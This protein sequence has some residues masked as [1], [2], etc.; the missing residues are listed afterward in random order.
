[1]SSGGAEDFGK[2]GGKNKKSM[3]VNMDGVTSATNGGGGG[4]T[5]RGG[6]GASSKRS[7]RHRGHIDGETRF[8]GREMRLTACVAI[9][10][11]VLF[12]LAA[13]MLVSGPLTG[14]LK[15]KCLDERLGF[16]GLCDSVDCIDISYRS[17]HSGNFS[18][19]PC[20]D[21][22]H[23]ACSKWQAQNPI[24]DEQLYLAAN[25]NQLRD[26]VD[27]FLKTLLEQETPSHKADPGVTALKNFYKS[28]TNFTN[29]NETELITDLL[30]SVQGYKTTE[31]WSEK[32]FDLTEVILKFLKVNA[33]PLIDLTLDI[34]AKNRER[35]ALIIE[36]PRATSL[37]PNLFRPPR[38]D[39]DLMNSEYAYFNLLENGD[40]IP[41]PNMFNTTS[42]HPNSRTP[43]G[44]SS[45]GTV[46]RQALYK[47]IKDSIDAKKREHLKSLVRK[48]GNIIKMSE[49]EILSDS[50][51]VAV[52]ALNI[53]KIKPSQRTRKFWKQQ[54]KVYNAY[55]L[56]QLQHQFGTVN[57]SFLF[58]ELM[59]FDDVSSREVPDSDDSYGKTSTG[60]RSRN[61][62]RGSS[63]R[64]RT[65]KRSTINWHNST[66]YVPYPD[67]LR[68]ILQMTQY[69]NKRML[70]NT[71][72]M[73]YVKDMLHDLMPRSTTVKRDEHPQQQQQQ[74]GPSKPNHHHH[75]QQHQEQQQQQQQQQQ[76]RWKFC[77][78]STKS[79]F[80]MELSSLY[81]KSFKPEHLE[82]IA[83]D[84]DEIFV[85]V[86]ETLISFLN[87]SI[88][89]ST[90]EEQH[91]PPNLQQNQVPSH[92]EKGGNGGNN[93]VSNSN[94]YGASNAGMVSG[95]GQGSE[96]NGSSSNSTSDT[97]DNSTTSTIKDEAIRKIATLK[98]NFLGPAFYLEEDF[99]DDAVKNIRIDPNNFLFNVKVVYRTFREQL[100]NLYWKPVDEDRATWA[101]VTF[102]TTV[103]AFYIQQFNSIVIPI[104]FLNP[105]HYVERAPKY[106][107][108]ATIALTIAHEALHALDSSGSDFDADGRL[109]DLWDEEPKAFLK[110]KSN[111]VA[112][113]YSDNFRKVLPFY[114]THVPI[115]VD[116]NLT[117]NENLADIAGLQVAFSAYR[118]YRLT[119]SKDELKKERR[120]PGLVL[121]LEQAYFL[122]VAQAY[123]A[124][125]S[126]M[127]YVFLLE[128]DEHS[129]HPERINGMLMNM[130]D[131][132]E[133]Y[134]CRPGSRMNPPVKCSVW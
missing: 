121:T 5:A 106:I 49:T 109:H 134:S 118:K 40:P 24:S 125:I 29:P 71:M 20:Q 61:R 127:G 69:T 123:C 6:G 117:Q 67:Y 13:F 65:N 99:L 133:A 9:L 57:W 33:A 87:R 104:A 50:Q 85:N 45:S 115:Q 31:F 59:G 35:Y 119:S 70:Y 25:I 120:I 18:A 129:P 89:L 96:N 102:P 2:S 76:P 107:N 53:E 122:T 92:Q 74:Q 17:V 84:V 62:S 23:F 47:M 112:K 116:G 68:R 46:D 52:I 95:N 21:F 32:D 79:V 105:P 124:N 132:T 100:Y 72:L 128:M 4:G 55:T 93:S 39:D 91:R 48:V 34:D 110:E 37:V 7:P 80:A 51:E 30:D 103:N 56:D 43:N 54:N 73:L 3:V 27:G 66:I 41:T 19:D 111:C 75:H 83:K 94:G 81:M 22:Y 11:I 77:V 12:G 10:T 14:L 113:L 26:S 64:N 15:P 97:N 82:R 16:S 60:G 63:K 38:Q 108:Y 101:F 90:S 78:Q 130:P 28:C 86:K 42:S 8:T 36:L 88:E 58:G 114:Q 1:M 44:S 126:P 131:F 98:G